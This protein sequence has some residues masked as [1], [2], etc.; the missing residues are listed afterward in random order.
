MRLAMGLGKRWI[1]PAILALALAAPSAI[2]AVQ[3]SDAAKPH[4][5]HLILK[6]GSYQIVVSYEISG[7]LVR[8]ISAERGGAQEEIPLE[9]VDL[10]AT[11]KWEKAHAPVVE[12]DAQGRP[13]AIDPELLKEEEE[14]TALTPFVEPDLRLPLEDSVLAEDEYQGSP[15]LVPLVQ[16]DGDLNHTTSHSVL[17]KA[18]NPKAASH[19]MLTLKGTKSYVQL[20]VDTPV[21]YLRIGEASEVSTGSAPLVVDTHGA[22]STVRDPDAQSADSQYVIVRTDVRI[23]ARLIASFNLAALDDNRPIEDVI[24]TKRE[25]LRGGH[26]L[27]LTP[28]KPLD[29]GEYALLEVLSP[30]EINLGVWDFGVHPSAPENRDALKPEPKK[31][32][33]LERRRKQE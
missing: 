22:S 25:T 33:D 8:Y 10:D 27:K 26:W 24:K 17:R 20:H 5:I 23:D 6:D 31:R 29:F 21:F 12:G 30:R 14:R 16:T 3:Q 28:D 9:L 13:P 19:Q 18:L 32:L 2:Q 11:R 15:E 4:R 7:S 1:S